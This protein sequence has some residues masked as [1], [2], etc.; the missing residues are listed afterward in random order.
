[1]H[2]AIGAAYLLAF[3]EHEPFPN[4]FLRTIQSPVNVR[5][6]LVPPVG[7]DFGLFIS[8][9]TAEIDC[10][11]Q[12]DFWQIARDVRNAIRNG[13][14]DPALLG[15]MAA[16]DTLFRTREFR[17]DRRTGASLSN[18]GREGAAGLVARYRRTALC[19]RRP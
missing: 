13:R 17:G 1:M 12:R 11:P 6:Q 7:E 9:V 14:R 8:H 19:S 16:A 3:A 2:G 18:R 15:R 4:S 5:A 10:G